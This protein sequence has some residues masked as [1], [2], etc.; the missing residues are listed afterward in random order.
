MHYSDV[1]HLSRD[2]KDYVYE[3]LVIRRQL[4]GY[5]VEDGTLSECHI[6][7]TLNDARMHIA[8][9]KGIYICGDKLFDLYEY[10]STIRVGEPLDVH[11]LF[12]DFVPMIALDTCGNR[13]SVLSSDYDP[14]AHVVE[15]V[16]VVGDAFAEKRLEVIVKD[17]KCPETVFGDIPEN[18]WYTDVL[19]A[20]KD[21]VDAVNMLDH[22]CPAMYKY[23][24]A[25]LDG[26]VELQRVYGR[27]ISFECKAGIDHVTLESDG[28]R[29]DYFFPYSFV[30]N[31]H[32]LELLDVD[33]YTGLDHYV[34]KDVESLREA[35]F[36]A[37]ARSIVAF[38]RGKHEEWIT[39]D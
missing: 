2:G 30:E 10:K 17:A 11:R 24:S 8:H 9:I 27:S 16:S 19:Y 35:V 6:C 1:I 7:N 21:I 18:M 22:C 34:G 5:T 23:N 20:V 38:R 32:I 4:M 3:N 13:V 31:D 12:D 29:L 26:L 39:R 36:T 25:I 14:S 33:G 28:R 37:C 15:R